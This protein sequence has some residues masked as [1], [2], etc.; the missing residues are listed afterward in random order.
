MV[1]I[2]QTLIYKVSF[3]SAEYDCVAMCASMNRKR[4]RILQTLKAAHENPK[5]LFLSSRLTSGKDCWQ[6][7]QECLR[8]EYHSTQCTV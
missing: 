4:S 3:L 6:L 7:I 2:C 5:A 1:L 8:C